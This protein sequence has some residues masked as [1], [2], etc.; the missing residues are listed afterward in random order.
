M[1][2][3]SPSPHRSSRWGEGRGEGQ[4]RAQAARPSPAGRSTAPRGRRIGRARAGAAAGAPSPHRSSRWGEGWGEGRVRAQAA[5][6]R[7][8][9]QVDWSRCPHGLLPLTLTL[10]PRREER[11][12]ERGRAH[13]RGERTRQLRPGEHAQP[14]RESG[15]AQ[16]R[17]RAPPLPIV[18]H[19]G[20]R[21]GVR[22][23]CAHRPLDRAPA[24]GGLVL[25]PSRA[26][27]PHPNPLPTA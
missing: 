8:L 11:R 4:V 6:P 23:G 18:L 7:P 3:N 9:R 20:E 14:L 27:A 19:D 2:G 17:R 13:R 26:S 21:V 5:R 22:G 24:A 10:S 25:V 16:A 1:P 12:G 15:Y